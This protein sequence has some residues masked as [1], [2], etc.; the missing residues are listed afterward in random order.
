MISV[1]SFR[2]SI[3]QLDEKKNKNSCI[4][5]NMDQ[6]PIFFDM[7]GKYT[8]EQIYKKQVTVKKTKGDKMR[9][10]FMLSVTSDGILLPPYIIVKSNNIKE[11]ENQFPDESI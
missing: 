10:T 9:V 7:A 8:F 3:E 2:F 4:F 5:I 1:F 11:L 6:T